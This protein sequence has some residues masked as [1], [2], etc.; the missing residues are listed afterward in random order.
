MLLIANVS[1]VS[2][3]KGYWLHDTIAR[4]TIGLVWKIV[5]TIHHNL[6]LDTRFLVQ[7]ADYFW[8]IL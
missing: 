3:I 5:G 1:E 4:L 8:P 2:S 7:E 6:E